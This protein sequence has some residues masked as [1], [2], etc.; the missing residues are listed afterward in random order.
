MGLTCAD[1]NFELLD[2]SSSSPHVRVESLGPQA[3]GSLGLDVIVDAGTPWGQLIAQVT[4]RLRGQ[5][6]GEAGVIEHEAHV[7]LQ[8]SIINKLEVN[9]LMFAV[10]HVLPG[11]SFESTVRLR[12]ADGLGFKVTRAEVLNAVPADIQVAIEPFKIGVTEGVILRLKG[13]SADY[14]GLVRAQVAFETDIPGEGPRQL[15]VMGIVRE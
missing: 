9:P 6:P 1:P 14:L 13:Q 8:A 7:R 2:L 4:A 11:R 15:S 3:D 5:V 10:G 12:R